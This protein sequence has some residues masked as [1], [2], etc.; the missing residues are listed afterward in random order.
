MAPPCSE[1]GRAI[2]DARA[3]STPRGNA[4]AIKADHREMTSTVGH[5]ARSTV[6]CLQP[7]SSRIQR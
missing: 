6:L 7:I 2:A 5:T 4:T 1:R 3:V